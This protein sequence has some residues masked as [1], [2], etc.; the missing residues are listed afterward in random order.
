[1]EYIDGEDL[2][3][4]LRRI[5]RLPVDKALEIGC[6]LASGLA[7]VHDLG[8]LHRDLKPANVMID[9]RG[10]AR[11]TDF[12]TA[13]LTDE[14]GRSHRA[15]TPAYMAPEQRRGGFASVESDL[16]ALGLILY[17]MLTGRPAAPAAGRPERPSPPS[18]FVEGI[19]PRTESVLLRCLDPDPRRRPASALQVSAALTGRDPFAVAV[20]A[21]LTLPP[22]A[23]AAAPRSGSLRPAVATALLVTALAGLGTVL[24]FSGKVLAFRQV[25]FEQPPEV[26]VDRART[27]LRELGYAAVPYDLD[28]GFFSASE[29]RGY[30]AH[31][32]QL[33]AVSR[34][35][36]KRIL[37]GGR[38]PL[39]GFWY[40]ESPRLLLPAWTETA[41]SRLPEIPPGGIGVA[42]D[43]KGR[44]YRLQASPSLVPSA[45]AT[46]E[47]AWPLLLRRAG[48]D[49]SRLLVVP[50]RGVPP[51]YADRRVAWDLPAPAELLAPA[52]HV[53]AASFRGTPVWFEVGGPWGRFREPE[54]GHEERGIW[55][56]LFELVLSFTVVWQGRR[57]LRL[58]RGDKRRAFLLAVIVFA[59]NLSYHWGTERHIFL[60]LE[61]RLFEKLAIE[62]SSA[63]AFW[64]LYIAFEP[65][66]RRL[67]PERIVTWNRLLAGRFRDALVGRDLL[68]GSVLGLG[69]LVLTTGRFSAGTTRLPWPDLATLEGGLRGPVLLLLKDLQSSMFVSM[70]FMLFLF[71]LRLLFRREGPAVGVLWLMLAAVSFSPGPPTT[72]RLGLSLL[73][74]G[75]LV[76]AWTRFGVLAGLVAYLTRLLCLS[77]P[78]TLDTS[79]WYWGSTLFAVLIVLTL[80]FYGFA[81]TVAGRPWLGSTAELDG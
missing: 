77:Y 55:I 50:P 81:H 5:G 66:V 10:R 3:G 15:G 71:G 61:D 25:R 43:P 49:P 40:Q 20:H 36:M 6:Q 52:L 65:S 74:S 70:E 14:L 2:A 60:R 47:T 45:A 7:A 51:V 28:S 8:L 53:E 22:E 31:L 57:N 63:V 35:E 1:M 23:V 24:S 29:A 18:S 13:I 72:L 21:G 73:G 67:S 79:A 27:L 44:L 39:F 26:L 37:A 58:G 12:G 59:L 17:E 69:A 34:A 11:I 19:D 46:A 64:L 9:G 30:L 62:I 75:L 48:L 32:A 41:E 33:P 42:L 76:F 16:Y 56:L 54:P 38:P 4:L 78:M 68:V 80:A